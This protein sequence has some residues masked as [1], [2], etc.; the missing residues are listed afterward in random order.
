MDQFS[1]YAYPC[2]HDFRLAAIAPV[3]TIRLKA[4]ILNVWSRENLIAVTFFNIKEAK[5]KI[6]IIFQLPHCFQQT[7]IFSSQDPQTQ[8]KLE[9][10]NVIFQLPYDSSS[11]ESQ[12]FPNYL[13]CFGGN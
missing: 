8:R 1:C 2:P 10:Q 7:S 6:T 3:I 13:V 12:K 11:G 9:K 5:K 4:E